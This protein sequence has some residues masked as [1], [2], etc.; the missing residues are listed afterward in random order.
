VTQV[1]L[2]RVRLN[3]QVTQLVYIPTDD[4]LCMYKDLLYV[5]FLKK[6]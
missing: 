3:S 2:S 1:L 4:H 5:F 6:N